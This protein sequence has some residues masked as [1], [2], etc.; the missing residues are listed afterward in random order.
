EHVDGTADL[1]QCA[2][3]ALQRRLHRA[4]A[5]QFGVA[6]DDAVDALVGQVL[7]RRVAA[8]PPRLVPAGLAHFGEEALPGQRALEVVVRA[9]GAHAPVEPARGGVLG[10]TRHAAEEGMQEGRPAAQVDD[11]HATFSLPARTSKA[12]PVK[13]P[14]TVTLPLPGSSG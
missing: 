10:R 7:A 12:P 5:E 1:R 14:S 9:P 3:H 2:F 8:D 11:L 6:V 4:D 13:A